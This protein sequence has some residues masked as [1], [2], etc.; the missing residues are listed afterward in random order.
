MRPV[1]D[2]FLASVR[3]GGRLRTRVTLTPVIGDPVDLFVIDG[4]IT[5]DRTADRRGRGSLTISA[6]NPLTGEPV[7]T[8]QDA[9]GAAPY[10]AT[11]QVWRGFEYVA[12]SIEVVS[13]GIYRLD[14][15]PR[16]VLEQQVALDLVDLSAQIADERFVAPRTFTKTTLVE[17][18]I[19]D[20]I[21]DVF[22]SA[23][24][25]KPGDTTTLGKRTVLEQDRWQACID[26]ATSIGCNIYPDADGDWQLVDVPDPTASLSVW[27]V[28]ASPEGVMIDATINQTRQS[29]YNGVVVT[30]EP[31]EKHAPAYALVTDD[32]PSSPTKW[33][34][35]FGRVP[36]FYSSE[37]IR[38]NTQAQA[39]GEARL[40][41]LLG[42]ARSVDLTAVPNPALEPGDQ[43]ETVF[44]DGTSE[45]HLIDAVTIGLQPDGQQTLK[46]RATVAA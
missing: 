3:G 40:R 5:L 24:V 27:S 34:G 36:D 28:D 21:L 39:V 8:N 26:F 44:P 38:D 31:A 19:E 33:G 16:Q 2:L 4:S 43:I 20:L 17:D 30:G 25:H 32:D 13:L 29:V 10:G 7:T 1:S 9:F 22:P 11:V 42:V 46:T 23:T 14:S 6:V 35:P 12:G 15:A 45:T 37:T 41:D 18:A